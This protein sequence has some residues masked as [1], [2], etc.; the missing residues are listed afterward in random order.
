M[1]PEAGRE[2]AAPRQPH[3]SMNRMI[4]T[5]LS[6]AFLA[7]L[8]LLASCVGG[9]NVVEPSG[10]ADRIE[11]PKPTSAGLRPGD[12]INL[13][14]TGVPDAQDFFVK[15]DEEG[16][17][18]V[19]YLGR[20]DVAGLN[21][22][23]LQDRIREMYLERGIYNNVYVSAV[24]TERVVTLGGEVMRSGP[25]L[26]RPDLTLSQAVQAAGGYS[27]YARKSK[28]LLTREGETYYLDG[29]MAEQNPRWDPVLYPGD[30]ITVDRSAF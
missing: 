23:E 14:I 2:A 1:N 25:V 28:V 8:F 11:L 19:R 13:S 12:G 27:L 26:W 22:S 20:I 10:E 30:V 6:L 29:D 3:L 18:S 7:G 9:G 24:I 16:M 15:V 17:I 5:A 21:A 4:R